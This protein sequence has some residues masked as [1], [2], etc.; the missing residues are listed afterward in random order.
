[1]FISLKQIADLKDA[2]SLLIPRERLRD[3]ETVFIKPNLGYTAPY[4]MTTSLAALEETLSCFKGIKSDLNLVVGEGSASPS[5]ALQNANKLGVMPLLQREN[6]Q[7]VDLD[8]ED[9]EVINGIG[10]PK[11]VIAAD[12]RVSLPCIKISRQSDLL[13]SCA[14]KNYL[15]IP[16]KAVHSE[17]EHH[18]RDKFHQ[19]I[20]GSIAEVYNAIQKAAPFELHVV[21]GTTILMGEENVGTEK[22]W[23]KILVGADAEE[24][25]LAICEKFNLNLPQYLTLLRTLS[26]PLQE[27]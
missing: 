1:M 24:I 26:S 21:D 17:K 16:S 22:S 18:R 8:Q 23:G 2:L 27:T 20:H 4:P 3:L 5:S 11:V 25:D 6:V 14:I 13:L 12:F 9:Y 19:D 10:I 7:F 15:G